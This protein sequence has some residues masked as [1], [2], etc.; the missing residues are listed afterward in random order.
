MAST[1]DWEV[2]LRD[3]A[4]GPANAI[5]SAVNSARSAMAGL[6]SAA[7]SV[8]VPKLTIDSSVNR[9]RDAQGR[10]VAGAKKTSFADMGAGASSATGGLDRLNGSVGSLVKMQLAEWAAAGAAKLWELAKGAAG[11]GWDFAKFAISAASYKRDAIAAFG[12][13]EGS[14]Q[15]AK[16]TF[17]RINKLADETPFETANVVG[18]FKS[19][20]SAGLGQGEAEKLFMAMSDIASVQGADGKEMLDRLKQAV[21]KIKGVGKLDMETLLQVS[22]AGSAAGINVESILTEVAKMRG[23]TIDA[24]RAALSSGNAKNQIKWDEAYKAIQAATI[25]QV[26]KGGALGTATKKFGL[27][28]LDGAIST[29][30]SKLDDLFTDI[31]LGP[32][33]KMI[34]LVASLLDVTNANFP[35]FQELKTIVEKAFSDI[36]A[37]IGTVANE[38][39]LKGFVNSVLPAVQFLA[40]SV[41]A[42]FQ[43]GM[44]AMRG[45][46]EGFM[47][48]FAPIESSRVATQTLAQAL[49][50]I[51]AKAQGV[52]VVV[53]ALGG[54]L[55]SLGTLVRDG[56]AT[57][58]AAVM[59]LVTA[60]YNSLAASEKAGGGFAALGNVVRVL[61][62]GMSFVLT[63]AY[64]LAAW[65]GGTLLMA[66]QALGAAFGPMLSG[67]LS[68]ASYG[69]KSTSSA[70]AWAGAMNMLSSV[71]GFVTNVVVGLG[72]V[73]GYL[74]GAA[75]YV[76]AALWNL[77]KMAAVGWSNIV[78][79]IG[80]SL[81]GTIVESI[82]QGIVGAWDTVAEGV[83]GLIGDLPGGGAISAAIGPSVAKKP[84]AGPAS[85]PATDWAALFGSGPTTTG[86]APLA[87][88]PPTGQYNA[89]AKPV[90]QSNSFTLNMPITV[91]A[92]GDPS[93]V[94]GAVSQ[95]ASAAAPGVRDT[96]AT[97]AASL[98][99]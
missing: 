42:L 59:P 97:L 6:S 60:I 68:F 26:N 86:A 54:A 4:S 58:G 24:A 71:L 32:L 76:I 61:Y 93:S 85:K 73:L 72:A 33:V 95:G 14:S 64:G 78:T 7:Q 96:F 84:E 41:V 90:N 94:A 38:T 98:G 19:L 34:Q 92:S 27:E 22:E 50:D 45:F 77:L 47:S 55:V 25:A 49:D 28:S 43:N 57:A 39:S 53:G 18:I 36:F 82:W 74:L 66:V 99:V 67:A 30:K 13:I 8:R 79:V 17:A 51:S 56:Y 46:G 1:I 89:M 9:W 88:M 87:P 10:F 69:D 52:G 2:R 23:I 5:K 70:T 81:G 80:E 83:A 91:S 65:L 40:E 15:K 29:L 35:A 63:V 48:A 37:A 75:A 21:I 31:D 12:L 20:R 3:L 44:A 62:T 16:E 11:V